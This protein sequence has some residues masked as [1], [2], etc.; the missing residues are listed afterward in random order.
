[1]VYF[2]IACLILFSTGKKITAVFRKT[3]A[4]AFFFFFPSPGTECLHACKIMRTSCLQR[5]VYESAQLR[6]E[7]HDTGSKACLCVCAWV[8]VCW[9][10]CVQRTNIWVGNQAQMKSWQVSPLKFYHVFV[11][12]TSHTSILATRNSAESWDLG[13]DEDQT[14]VSS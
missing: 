5:P 10:K 14:L 8:W 3:W 1:M 12:I 9:W 11:G 13:N 4:I 2:Y 7:S 6:K